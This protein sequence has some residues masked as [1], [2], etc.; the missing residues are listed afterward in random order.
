MIE[1]LVAV[2][3]LLANP[4]TWQEVVD[5]DI[6]PKQGSVI[7]LHPDG[8]GVTSWTALRLIDE[9]P[10]GLIHWD[11]MAQMG[12]YRGHPLDSVASSS[13]A[14]A[15]THAFGKK[16]PKDSYGMAAKEPLTAL[17][18]EPLSIAM[19]AHAAGIP[20]GIINSGHLA[21]PGTGVFAASSETR[22]DRTGIAAKI[23]D[24]GLP[25]IMAGG[26]TLLLPDGE[27]GHF[28][29]AG[30]RED[31]RNLIVE[32]RAKGYTV[33]Y[34]REQLMA[35]DVEA[36]EKVLGVFAA[37]H[38][39]NDK[40]EEV[41]AEEGLP[42][43]LDTAPTI[44]EMTDFALRF[45][46]AKG[47]RFFL[48]AEEEGTDNFANNGNAIGTIEAT[49]RADAAIGHV[50]DYIEQNARTLLVT[51]ADSNAGNM[52]IASIDNDMQQK[53]PLPAQSPQGAP[54]DGQ[55]GPNSLP[56]LTAPDAQGTR[57][58]FAII[59]PDYGDYHGGVIAKAH[60]LNS[61]FLP[62]NVQNADIYKLM[63]ATLFGKLLD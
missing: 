32:A 10:D 58:H 11:R 7:F 51:A 25:L 30:V 60:G 53:M 59:W 55:E 14:G 23:L 37:N 33:V 52:A 42:L 2:A 61:E 9:G 15:T 27:R 63:Y 49:R 56:F 36:T 34:N 45:L 24:S 17:S 22:R 8:T 50:M 43:F 54:I 29:V 48:V 3:M 28:D 20:T 6:E 38:T 4:M 44:A 18:G 41:L 46:S 13:H 31:G 5:Q 16:V 1:S 35:L 19:E 12:V 21:E 47:E 57:F 40:P 26:E 62:N 39:F